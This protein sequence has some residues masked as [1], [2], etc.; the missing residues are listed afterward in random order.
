MLFNPFQQADGSTTRRFGGTGLG[1]VISKR[2]VELMGGNIRVESEP[3]VG[4]TFSLFVP[5]SFNFARGPRKGTQT[6]S[7]VGIAKRTPN[8]ARLDAPAQRRGNVNG[9]SLS[10]PE[11]VLPARI[12]YG[13]E[14]EDDRAGESSG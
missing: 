3:G 6:D 8:Y 7:H 5:Q 10:Q 12:A 1:L 2:I 14:V 9:N 13:A 4:S 11:P